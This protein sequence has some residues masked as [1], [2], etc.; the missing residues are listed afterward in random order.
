MLCSLARF[1]GI[2][3]FSGVAGFCGL[4]GRLEAGNP[5]L[6]RAAGT[7]GDEADA[8]RAVGCVLLP[9]REVV[10]VEDVRDGNRAVRAAQLLPHRF[11]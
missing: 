8:L 11:G 6:T 2:D 10:L 4:E 3:R 1:C 9:G 7:Y 5:A